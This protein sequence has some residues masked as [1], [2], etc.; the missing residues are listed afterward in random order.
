MLIALFGVLLMPIV[1][2]VAEKMH[3]FSLDLVAGS[4]FPV[5]LPCLELQ[6]TFDQHRIAFLEV[7]AARLS[8]LVPANHGDVAYLLLLLAGFGGPASV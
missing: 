2:P 5:F 3:P 4:L 6:A 7:F 8:L 1:L